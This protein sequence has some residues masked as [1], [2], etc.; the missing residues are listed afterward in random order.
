MRKRKTRDWERQNS[1]GAHISV[2]T[3]RC[4]TP[5][6]GIGFEQGIRR[7]VAAA[8]IVP[9]TC[10]SRHVT[11]PDLEG[12][13]KRTLQD[14]LCELQMHVQWCLPPKDGVRQAAE[15]AALSLRRRACRSTCRR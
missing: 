13:D 3:A 12:G 9:Q 4:R 15:D 5:T 2:S 6:A 14:A 8:G 11:M 7:H 10:V 1:S